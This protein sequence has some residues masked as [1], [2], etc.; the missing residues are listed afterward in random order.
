MRDSLGLDTVTL[1]SSIDNPP[2]FS[3]PTLPES[4]AD[5]TYD[6]GGEKKRARYATWNM[7]DLPDC[8]AAWLRVNKD[9]G[10]IK[11]DF[12]AKILGENYFEGIKNETWDQVCTR[13]KEVH[14]LDVSDTSSWHVSR[15]DV[16]ANLPVKDCWPYIFSAK[17]GLDWSFHQPDHQYDNTA[18]WHNKSDRL[19]IYDKLAEMGITAS[20]TRRK[21]KSLSIPAPASQVLRIEY[22]ANKIEKLRKRIRLG[23]HYLQGSENPIVPD[24]MLS[25]YL[26]YKNQ[27]IVSL[28]VWRQMKR[29]NGID[30]GALGIAD[31]LRFSGLKIGTVRRMLGDVHLLQQIG[32][33]ATIRAI[34]WEKCP[35]QTASR[36]YKE[37]QKSW[38][39]PDR[40]ARKI[41]D[42]LDEI[43]ERIGAL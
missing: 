27:K 40:Q 29:V 7:R 25:D 37:M 1:R 35:K 42:N 39:I 43:D 8:P 15:A 34:L 6:L 14:G 16:T 13:I 18:L 33:R 11:L 12:S 5:L 3:P 24:P 17:H 19:R 2:A 36:V 22:Q 21:K 4:E 28:D 26:E 20:P 10:E 38:Q 23:S 30:L 31:F 41:A 9:S 32:D